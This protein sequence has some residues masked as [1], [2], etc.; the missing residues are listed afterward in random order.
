MIAIELKVKLPLLNKGWQ[1]HYERERFWGKS[2]NLQVAMAMNL[3][4]E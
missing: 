1:Y 4:F 3:L 2:C